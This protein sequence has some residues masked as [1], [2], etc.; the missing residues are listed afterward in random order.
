M[1]VLLEGLSYVPGFYYEKN[2]SFAEFLNRVRSGELK[3]QSQGLWDVPHPWLNMF[4]P[5]SRIT[6]FDS[7][8]FKDIILR[9]NITTGPVLVYPMNRS[10]YVQKVFFSYKFLIKKR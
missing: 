7:G 9:Q 4:I 6:D 10:K 8:V 1:Q 3:L 5:K 2:V